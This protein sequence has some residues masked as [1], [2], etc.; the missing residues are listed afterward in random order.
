M[1]LMLLDWRILEEIKVTPVL[2]EFADQVVCKMN[3]W[4]SKEINLPLSSN[5]CIQV[6]L[7]GD[8]NW[9]CPTWISC[10][11]PADVFFFRSLSPQ[12]TRYQPKCSSHKLRKWS[13]QTH[14]TCLF[15]YSV[16]VYLLSTY[17]L[18]GTFLEPGV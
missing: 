18:S 14:L 15:V 9:T 12:L 16:N 17:Y 1:I 6:V 13:Q 7:W 4:K 8:V 11:S 5:A 10:S 3:E 2:S